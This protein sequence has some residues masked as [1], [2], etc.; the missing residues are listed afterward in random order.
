MSQVQI[1]EAPLTVQS[2]PL[3]STTDRENSIPWSIRFI[4]GCQILAVAGAFFDFAWHMSIGRE[5]FW[6][7]AHLMMQSSAVLVGIAC[8]REILITTFAGPSRAHNTSVRILGL[9]A[10]VGT[11]IALWGSAAILGSGPWD[12]W[13]H[14]AYG[15]DVTIANP[16]HILLALGGFAHQTGVMAWIANVSNRS[17]TQALRGRLAW[18]LFIEGSISLA[19]IQLMS[20]A[21]TWYTEMHTAT[22]YLIVAIIIPAMLVAC[23]CGSAQKWGCTITAALYTVLYLADLWF[24][25]LIPAQPKLGPVYHHVT[26]MVPVRFPMLLIV[27]A[28]VADLLFQRL[29]RRSSWIKALCIGSAFV[30]SF[31]IVQW[32]FA[33]FL[34]S[35]AARNGIFGSAYF[36]FVDPAGVL[37]DPYEF[38]V[39]EKTITAFLLT[40]VAAFVASILTSR[41]GIAWGNWMRRLYR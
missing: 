14:N 18:L 25:P 10:P 29:E 32:P 38:S 12:N 39:V 27:P 33:S 41:L 19:E 31:L 28:F 5:T 11:F 40:M 23:G 24:M 17:K 22:F 26:H 20:N 35:P 2:R 13:F 15:L 6:T 34:A 37:Y 8:V 3:A 16:P 1:V 9:Y 36:A 4:V 21:P 30:L 7:P